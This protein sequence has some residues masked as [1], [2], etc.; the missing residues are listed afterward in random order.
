MNRL[1]GGENCVF[2]A[3]RFSS[4]V[5]SPPQSLI[6]LYCLV[7]SFEVNNMSV[8]I[9]IATKLRI[10]VSVG[11]FSVAR[12]RVRFVFYLNLSYFSVSLVPDRN[13]KFI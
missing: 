8:P 5:I 3:R 4:R 6:L 10:A 11:E 12:F 2:F 13:E 7:S 9:L 1:R